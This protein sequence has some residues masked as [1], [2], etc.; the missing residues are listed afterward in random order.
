MGIQTG[1]EYHGDAGDLRSR[2]E[3][4]EKRPLVNL[5]EDTPEAV[6]CHW[7][8]SCTRSMPGLKWEDDIRRQPP[9]IQSTC[10]TPDPNQVGEKER[11]PTGRKDE[12]SY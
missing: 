9:A 10:H 1:R 8:S 7:R 3:Y 4:V 2:E 6:V 5:T 12:G 11:K